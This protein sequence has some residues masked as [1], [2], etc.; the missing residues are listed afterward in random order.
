ME[1]CLCGIT[2][3]YHNILHKVQHNIYFYLISSN[4]ISFMLKLVQALILFFSPPTQHFTSGLT[5]DISISSLLTTF[6]LVLKLLCRLELDSCSLSLR[7]RV[8]VLEIVFVGQCEVFVCLDFVD[9]PPPPLVTKLIGPLMGCQFFKIP[10]VDFS[11]TWPLK[12]GWKV[13]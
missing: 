9:F 7:G 12:L 3:F 8:S 13:R 5:L 10:Y 2:L 1:L 4:N 11:D 6:L